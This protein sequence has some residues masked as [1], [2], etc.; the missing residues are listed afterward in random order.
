MSDTDFNPTTF[1]WFCCDYL[2]L[3]IKI[4]K[5]SE[6]TKQVKPDLL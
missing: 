4:K 3:D 1:I 5:E 2:T 6:L